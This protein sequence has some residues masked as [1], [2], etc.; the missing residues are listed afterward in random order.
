V[1]DGAFD[2]YFFQD[3][4]LGPYGPGAQCPG[5]DGQPADCGMAF[6]NNFMRV[7]CGGTTSHVNT[8]FANNTIVAPGA[9][10]PAAAAAIVAAAGPRY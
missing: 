3:S 1:I 7:S 6:S 2:R 8:S 9:P 5:R 10:L 4:S